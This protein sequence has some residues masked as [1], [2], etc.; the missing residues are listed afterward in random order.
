MR[1][2]GSILL[3]IHKKL[4]A[5]EMARLIFENPSRNMKQPAG[6]AKRRTRLSRGS[7]GAVD[8]L[9]EKCNSEDDQCPF[10]QLVN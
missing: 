5:L 8:T 9:T 1:S 4:E 10:T 2:C 3:R 7:G 6:I